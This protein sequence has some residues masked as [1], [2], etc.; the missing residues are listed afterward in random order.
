MRPS[1]LHCKASFFTL[2]TM[3]KLYC[4]KKCSTC[5]QAERFLSDLQI[6]FISLPIRDTPPT[7]NELKLMLSLYNGQLKTIMNTSGQD[8]RN[9][10]YKEKIGTMRLESVFA[11]MQ[12][13]GNL[14]KRPFLINPASKTGIV[15]FHIDKWTAFFTPSL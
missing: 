10:G 9:Q 13:C 4:Y 3:Y 15:G 5:R 11:D 12:R 7:E 8:Y 6:P 2:A 1:H 14:V